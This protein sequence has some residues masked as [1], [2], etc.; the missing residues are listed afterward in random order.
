MRNKIVEQGKSHASLF[1]ALIPRGYSMATV[2][3]LAEAF[4]TS[5]QLRT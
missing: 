3:M 1:A 4:I 5:V 2:L